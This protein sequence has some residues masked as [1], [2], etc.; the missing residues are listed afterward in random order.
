MVLTKDMEEDVGVVGVAGEIA[1]LI[2]VCCCDEIRC[3][4][5]APHFHAYYQD[6]VG[7]FTIDPIELL[8]RGL[9][10]RQR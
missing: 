2:A 8:A 10:R 6:E 7:I 9:P 5:H 1:D 3:P 4:H